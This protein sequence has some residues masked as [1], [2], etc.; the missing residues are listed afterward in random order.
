MF[1]KLDTLADSLTEIQ[2]KYNTLNLDVSNSEINND[3]VSAPVTSN[4][5]S[6][7]SY[8]LNDSKL[9]QQAKENNKEKPHVNT[10]NSSNIS[11]RP[12]QHKEE[13]YVDRREKKKQISNLL[14]LALKTKNYNDYPYVTTAPP[15][16]PAT[17][18]I[19]ES[20]MS[21]MLLGASASASPASQTGYSGLLASSS[22]TSSSSYPSTKTNPTDLPQAMQQKAENVWKHIYDFFEHYNDRTSDDDLIDRRLSEARASIPT[23]INQILNSNFY[24]NYF[25]SSP[26][27]N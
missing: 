5:I 26:T 13:C 12:P 19:S 4:D 23:T 16:T 1:L 21:N 17:S 24:G 7:A 8:N 11:S 6:K 25:D 18:L 22:T 10:N 14:K 20:P 2:D 15:A 3:A 27:R 9:Q